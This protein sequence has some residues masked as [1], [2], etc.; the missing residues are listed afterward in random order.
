MESDLDRKLFAGFSKIG[1]AFK[2]HRARQGGERG[3]SPTQ[4]QV[5]AFLKER[6]GQA[7]SLSDVADRM[8]VT[9]PTVSDS[10]SGLVKK[11]LVEK[12]ASPQDGRRLNLT[13]T[14][15]GQQEAEF[16]AAW[17][18]FFSMSLQDLKDEEKAV[19]HRW[20][21]RM[22][23]HLQAQGMIPIVKMCVNCRFFVAQRYSD[24]DKPHHCAFLDAPIGDADLILDCPDSEPASAETMTENL[25]KLKY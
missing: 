25:G 13:L 11:S 18:E 15:A 23:H 20:L 24:N 12:V 1:L 4:G 19:M 8:G 6:M 3:L 16:Q 17:P 10:V 7:T 2:I 21:L 5:L 14:S 22:I 9:L